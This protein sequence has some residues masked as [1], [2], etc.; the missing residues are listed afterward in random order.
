MRL[1]NSGNLYTKTLID[2]AVRERGTFHAAGTDCSPAV[3][4]A[5]TI[6]QCTGW[7][8]KTMIAG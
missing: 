7:P 2:R 8:N 4:L 6:P 1:D 5:L 3:L